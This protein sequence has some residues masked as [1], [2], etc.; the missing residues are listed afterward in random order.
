MYQVYSA[1]LLIESHVSEN[2]ARLFAVAVQPPKRSRQAGLDMPVN[3]F[4]HG[5]VR[6]GSMVAYDFMFSVNRILSTD[7]SSCTSV[8]AV[9]SQLAPFAAFALTHAVP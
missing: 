6:T 2:A 4:C 7:V 1:T 3:M 5:Y 8:A 9:T